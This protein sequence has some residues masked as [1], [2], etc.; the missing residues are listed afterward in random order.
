[1][2]NTSFCIF[3]AL[4]DVVIFLFIIIALNM[5]QVLFAH[6]F[7]NFFS[8]TVIYPSCKGD[9]GC[10]IIGLAITSFIKIIVFLGSLFLL[11]LAIKRFCQSTYN[12]HR[13]L[14]L[15]IWV[16]KLLIFGQ[17]MALETVKINFPYNGRNLA[18]DFGL[19]ID[20]LF[21]NIVLAI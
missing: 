20:N 4:I 11:I 12:G 10:T 9:V 1:M 13:R 17:T 16:F 15:W 2:T 3:W 14:S 19:C 21:N 7:F 6:V 5:A 8:H 18:S